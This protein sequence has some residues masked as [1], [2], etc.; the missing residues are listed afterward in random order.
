MLLLGLA[1]LSVD[2]IIPKKNNYGVPTVAADQLEKLKIAIIVRP[3][4]L[5]ASALMMHKRILCFFASPKLKFFFQKRGD[6]QKD[7]EFKRWLIS[8]LS[9]AAPGGAPKLIAFTE[10]RC[11]CPP[12]AFLKHW[13]SS[14]AGPPSLSHAW[15]RPTCMAHSY[16]CQMPDGP[17]KWCLQIKHLYFFCG[18]LAR[19]IITFI[20]Y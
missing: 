3:S 13:K 4:G 15:Y 5:S 7:S 20:C 6:K 16:I 17:S 19:A 2:N 18:S 14:S 10:R 9:R 11:R 1:L 12:A 8:F